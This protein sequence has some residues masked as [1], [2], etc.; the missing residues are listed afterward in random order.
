[1]PE[2]YTHLT[3]EQ[4]NHI[5]RYHAC[6]TQQAIAD[7][8]GVSQSTVSYELSRNRDDAGHYVAETAHQ[9][10]TARRSHASRLP[11]KVPPTFLDD[12]VIPGLDDG[13]HPKVIAHDLKKT[14]GP[15]VSA[16]WIYELIDREY[17]LVD[18]DIGDYLRR[19]YKKKSPFKR[20]N[21]AGVHSQSGRYRRTTA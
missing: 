14:G 1:M 17:R 11:R 2:G 12:Y 18:P 19:K 6:W 5:Q 3:R 16:K 9:K 15:R 8:L 10:T 13:R 20:A 4:R 7:S 21:G